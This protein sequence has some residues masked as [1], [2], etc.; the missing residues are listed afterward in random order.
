[1]EIPKPLE[2]A[3]WLLVIVGFFAIIYATISIQDTIKTGT[4]DCITYKPLVESVKNCS[5]KGGT[6]NYYCVNSSWAFNWT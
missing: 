5:E 4:I 1:M 2:Y 6:P 3:C